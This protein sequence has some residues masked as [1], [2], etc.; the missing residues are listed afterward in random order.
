MKPRNY[1]VKRNMSYTR[2]E[3]VTR[4]PDSRIVKFTM[5]NPAKKFEA[6]IRLV[7]LKSGQ[8]RNQ[9]LEAARIAA[10]RYLELHL[11]RSNYKFKIIP[12]PHQILRTK[13]RTMVAQADRFQEGM[14]LAYGSPAG[15][16]ARMKK[17]KTV[18]TVEVMEKD[19][20]IGRDALK[21][22]ADKLPL[23]CRVI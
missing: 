21:R 7:T 19:V 13:K 15:V 22:G 2:R 10:N 6:K 14:K 12:Y 1:R 5:G 9:A 3:Y 16:A 20:Q 4:I 8:I 17:R 11:G 23:P 18:L